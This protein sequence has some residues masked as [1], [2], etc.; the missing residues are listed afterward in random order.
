M[1]NVSRQRECLL[2]QV[3]ELLLEILADLILA[4]LLFDAA[5]RDRH[6]G[7][8]LAHVVVQVARDPRAFRFLGV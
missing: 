7:Q 4:Q 8:L 1:A 5:E 6:A 2:L 3:R